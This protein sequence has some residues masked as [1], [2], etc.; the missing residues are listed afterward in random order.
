LKK[1]SFLLD[2]F[3]EFD[4]DPAKSVANKTK[5]GLDFVEAHGLWQDER[6][7]DIPAR[8]DGE[9]RM[10]TIGTITGK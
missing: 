4:F 6:L 3:K 5:L 2:C 7:L 1:Y 9:P 8:L 10:L